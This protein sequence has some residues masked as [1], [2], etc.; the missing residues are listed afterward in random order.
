[1]NLGSEIPYLS[2]NVLL[3]KRFGGQAADVLLTT[4]SGYLG[5]Q[6]VYS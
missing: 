4:I 3:S 6:D 2:L 5:R 1:M